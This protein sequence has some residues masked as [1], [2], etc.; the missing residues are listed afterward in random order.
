MVFFTLNVIKQNAV[1]QHFSKCACLQVN[2]ATA[3]VVLPPFD[4]LEGFFFV[5]FK[6]EVGKRQLSIQMLQALGRLKSRSAT[7]AW[8]MLGVSS[9]FIFYQGQSTD[10]SLKCAA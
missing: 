7:L 8:C 4:R 6:L 10:V 5:C 2:Y 9:D 3:T 1:R